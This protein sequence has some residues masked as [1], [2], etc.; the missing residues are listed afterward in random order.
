MTY[1]VILTVLGF[2]AVVAQRGLHFKNIIA[3][4]E[5][6]TPLTLSVLLCYA[7]VLV[8][9]LSDLSLFLLDPCSVLRHPIKC[10]APLFYG[11]PP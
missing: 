1:S 7:M 5:R 10:R 9:H 6:Y 8:L 4:R 2:R 11:P 3:V